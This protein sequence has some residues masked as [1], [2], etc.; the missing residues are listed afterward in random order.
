LSGSV[1]ENE[2][3]LDGEAVQSEN[4]PRTLKKFTIKEQI[5]EFLY[6][7]DSSSDKTRAGL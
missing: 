4:I 1:I 2:L 5:S 6:S 7:S 3:F